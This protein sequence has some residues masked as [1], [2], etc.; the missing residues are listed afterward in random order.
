MSTVLI[1]G[2]SRGLGLEFVRQY[3]ADGWNV[4]A[5]CRAP[6]KAA[7]LQMLAQNKNVRIEALDVISAPSIATLAAKLKDTAID[8]LINNAGVFSGTGRDG[9]HFME[10]EDTT[11]SFGTLD[12]VAWDKVL[13]A[14][15][16]AP[17]M[18][19]QALVP[20]ILKGK[21]RK[22]IMI[23]SRMGSIEMAKE[24]D[25]AYRSSKA[26]LN[27]AMKNISITLKSD[28]V[29][30][31][32]FHPGWVKTDMG[33]ANAEITPGESIAGMRKVIVGLT[34]KD[35]GKFLGYDGKIYPW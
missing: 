23:T 16:I 1:T 22:I 31:V 10:A 3:A 20:N 11:Q 5:A 32:S 17:I 34:M 13:Q 12:P 26:A 15:A 28:Q 27:A 7:E 4:I 19:T 30:V 8:V 21:D 29:I 9:R 6:D 25:I 14:N 35:S 24:G 2:A 33:G 18:V